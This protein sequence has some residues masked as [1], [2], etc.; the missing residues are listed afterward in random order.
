MLSIP[1]EVVDQ[2]VKDSHSGEE[3]NQINSQEAFLKSD[4]LHVN[5]LEA[6]R[7]Q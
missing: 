4:C 7:F 2:K 5:I 6:P 1:D 3:S